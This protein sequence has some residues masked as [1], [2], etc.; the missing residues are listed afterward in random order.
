MYAM[1]NKELREAV[2]SPAADVTEELLGEPV[3]QMTGRELCTLIKYANENAGEQD[4]GRAPRKAVGVNA[5]AE[6]LSC[7]SSA[8][9]VL[10]RTPREEDGSADGGGVLRDVIVSRIG[11]SIVFDVEKARTLAVQAKQL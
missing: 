9:F 2:P 6:A 8:I 10:M 1:K 4:G 11:R 3:W 7:S 5:L